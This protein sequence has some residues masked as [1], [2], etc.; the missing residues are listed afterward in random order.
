MPAF[1]NTLQHLHRR[2]DERSNGRDAGGDKGRRT[3][4]ECTKIRRRPGNDSSQPEGLTEDDGQTKH[5]IGRILH[6]NKHQKDE[7]HENKQWEGKNSKNQYRWKRIGT[8]WKILL[9]GKYDH[10]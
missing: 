9:P 5:D 4:D 10:E 8:S 6:E 3:T 2:N 7:D 1:A